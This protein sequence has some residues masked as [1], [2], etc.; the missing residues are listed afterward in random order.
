MWSIPLPSVAT[1]CF[2]LADRDAVSVNIF[3]LI[4]HAKILTI[5]SLLAAVSRSF[6]EPSCNFLRWKQSVHISVQSCPS[7]KKII[8]SQ[9]NDRIKWFSGGGLKVDTLGAALLHCECS[10]TK[11]SVPYTCFT[12]TTNGINVDRAFLWHTEK[13]LGMPLWVIS[14]VFFHS[15]GYSSR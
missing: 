7:K 13:M 10:V 11:N 3:W 1:S 2:A 8:N 6:L 5:A 4:P 9:R 14:C 15:L 12:N